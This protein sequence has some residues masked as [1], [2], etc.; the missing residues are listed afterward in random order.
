MRLMAHPILRLP[1][2]N[3]P[4][5]LFTDASGFA[6]GAILSQKEDN[7]D[8]YVVAYASRS[9][10][11]AE[12]HYGISEKECLAVLW[13]IKHFRIYLYG[14]KF[15][16]IADHQALHWLMTINDPTGK[17]A[18]WSIYLQAYDFEIIHRRGRVH[19]NV[20]TLSR[21]V[22][23]S[24]AVFNTITTVVNTDQDSREKTLDIWEDEYA[25]HYLQFRRHVP[26]STKN[27]IKR[28]TK[29]STLLP[30]TR[31]FSAKNQILIINCL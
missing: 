10:K 20:D 15:E 26:G 17:L 16:V 9:L 14:V 22:L 18:R 28:I 13:A 12:N 8:E 31:S 1:D 30:T 5:T 29:F 19:Q 2:V 21:P 6:I 7:C 27:Q 25:L 4:F 23:F 11:G 24:A 3:R